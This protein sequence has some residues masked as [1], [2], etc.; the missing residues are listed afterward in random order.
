MTVFPGATQA[1][2]TYAYDLA[3]NVTRITRPDGSYLDYVYDAASRVTSVTNNTSEKIEYGYNLNSDVTAATTKTS[4]AVITRQMSMTYDELG[5]LLTSVG[6]AAQTTKMSYD[7]TDLRAQVKDPRNNLFSYGY[8][9]LQRLV[10][11]TDQ[12]TKTVTLT[13]NGQNDVTAYQD[14]RTITT[15]YTRNG[16]GEVTQETSPDAGATVYNARDA[17]G[18]VTQMTDGRGIV[19]NMSYDTAGR[20]LTQSYGLNDP[21]NVTY[22]YDNIT[23]PATNKG[24]GHLTRI[25]DQSGSTAFVYNALGQIITDTRV[26]A[27][28]TY[29]TSYLYNAAGNITQIT[30]PSGRIVIYARNTLGQVTGVTTKENAGAAVVNVATA[31]TYRPM[32]NLLTS[33]AHGNGLVTTAGYDLDYRL[34]SLALKDGA[35]N[36]SSLAYAYGDNLNLTGITDGVTAANSNTLSYSATNRLA[37]ASGA[38]GSNTFTY[39]SVGNRLTD[40]TTTK[41]RVATYATTSNRLNSMTE[42]AAAFRTYTY[43]GAGNILTDVRP[44]ETFAF[45]YNKRNRPVSVTRNSVAYATYGYNALQQLTTRSSTAVGAPIGQVAYIYDLEGHLIAEATASSGATTRDYIWAASNDNTPVDLPLAVAEAATL[46]MVHTD[47]LGLPIRMTDA[48]KSTVWQALYKPWGEVQTTSGSITNNLRFP[49]QLFQIETACAYN[50]NRHYDPITGR[51]TQPDPLRF[52]DGPSMYAYAGNSPAMKVDRLGLD[53]WTE[54]GVPEEGG[55]SLHRSICV[56]KYSGGRLCISFGVA[57]PDCLMNCKGEVYEDR[58]EPGELDR[59]YFQSTSAAQDKEIA[60]YFQSL[61]GSEGAYF[62]LGNNCRNFSWKIYDEL[63][64]KYNGGSGSGW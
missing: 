25:A 41:N 53:F 55:G 17:R 16:F 57:E 63:K 44:G 3:G 51:Y 49:G 8:D 4:G 10:T 61:I 20:L 48:A 59:P 11:M 23:T 7:R 35:L 1:L 33:L 27:A 39:D 45:T 58:S 9:S 31:M 26:I 2:T 43:D 64:K 32:S 56:G 18:L 34:S 52:V 36:V 24:K 12:E 30:S 46:Y 14:P 28:K 42:N 13:R 37:A 54:S 19:T 47:H 21:E 60:S 6:A 29:V 5:R 38:W 40:V 15:S 22:S 50:W 62:L